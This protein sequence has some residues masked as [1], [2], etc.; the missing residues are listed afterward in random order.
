[1]PVMRQDFVERRARGHARVLQLDDQQRQGVEEADQIR[2]A[3]VERAGDAELADRQEIIV[4][5]MPPINH[6]L[7]ST[8]QRERNL[9]R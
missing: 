3:G 2:P 7:N 9:S 6:P 1:M 8:M 4:W 5:R